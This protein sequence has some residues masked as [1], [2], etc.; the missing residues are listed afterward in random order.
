MAQIG[1]NAWVWS[2]PVNTEELGR[3]APL[4]ARMGFDLIEVGIE[5]TS[6][7]DYRRAAEIAKA[8]GLAVGVCAAMGPDR[9]LIHPDETIRSNGMG[10]LRHCID[11]ARTLGAANVCGPLYSAVGRTWQATDEERKR[12]VDLLVRQL[13]ELAKYAGERGVWL[14]V[15]PLNRFETSFINLASQAI[16]VAD[17][18]DHPACGVML[19]TFHMNIEEKSI[20][21]AIRAAGKRMRQLHACENDRGAPGV[22]TRALGRGRAG[23]PRHRVQRPLR[24]RV[25]HEQ[26]EVDREGRG[27]L[28]EVRRLAGRAGAERAGLLENIVPKLKPTLPLL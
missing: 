22:R 13:G 25:L 23:V 14:G 28:A 26:G 21:D 7:L 6:D 1:V 12:D 15:E 16:E 17:R 24:H 8:N 2:S 5:S 11:A 20:G 4:V 27:H 3:L 19:D 18:V 9:D 10:Y